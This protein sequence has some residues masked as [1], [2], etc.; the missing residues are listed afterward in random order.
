M[1]RCILCVFGET[2]FMM[3]S[4]LYVCEPSLGS[5]EC[6][7]LILLLSVQE[8]HH[9][10]HMKVSVHC[11]SASLCIIIDIYL[12][13]NL[14]LLFRKCCCLNWRLTWKGAILTRVCFMIVC[15]LCWNCQD[16]V[17]NEAMT[18]DLSHFDT[19][20]SLYH[21]ILYIESSWIWH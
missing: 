9:L 19:D 21:R 18:G 12:Y 2:R 5:S 7:A 20:Q 4:A 16:N 17:L 13:P 1:A 14:M 3:M 15:S 10:Y 8:T 6:C 11:F